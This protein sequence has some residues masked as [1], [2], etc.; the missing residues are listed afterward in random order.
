VECEGAFWRSQK[1]EKIWLRPH[2]ELLGN[3]SKYRC[4]MSMVEL[5]GVIWRS[6]KFEIKKKC[7]LNPW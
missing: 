5:E 3:A 6:W 7:A 4:K 2:G 1:H